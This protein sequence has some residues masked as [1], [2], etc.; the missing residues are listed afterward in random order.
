MAKGETMRQEEEELR[1]RKTE[2]DEAA[3]RLME[4]TKRAFPL[5]CVVRWYTYHRD[6]RYTQQGVVV[7]QPDF[8]LSPT[9]VEVRNLATGKITKRW[10]LRLIYVRSAEEQARLEAEALKE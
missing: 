7:R 9:D 10:A 1:L 2:H 8:L 5:G 3:V 6:N 4:Q